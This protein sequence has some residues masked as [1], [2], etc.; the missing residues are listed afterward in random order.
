[1]ASSSAPNNASAS[2]SA[3]LQVGD[4]ARASG[5]TVRAIHHYEELGL[6]RPDARSKGRFRL[7][8]ASAVTRV[9]WIG[10]LHELGMSLTEIQKVVAAWE[11]APS[12][13]RA[14]AEIRAVYRAK[15]EETRAQV[16]RLRAL[17]GELESSILYLDTCE[18]CEPE[19]LLDS[20]ALTSK[21]NGSVTVPNRPLECPACELRDRE[22]EPDLVAG[23]HAQ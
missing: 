2:K 6:L 14:M 9:R 13:G 15:L 4:L 18:T 16:A 1:M 11:T 5:K 12:A 21:K 19:F 7:Y 17:E 10:K 20:S 3:P 8:D 22:A 23:I